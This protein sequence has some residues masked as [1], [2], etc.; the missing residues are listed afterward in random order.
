M[1]KI[2]TLLLALLLV[3]PAM[4]QTSIYLTP[5]SNWV[6]GDAWFAMYT[7]NNSGN[8]WFKMTP[9]EGETNL[10][11]AE[12]PAGYTNIIFC[13]MNPS[14]TALDWSAKWDQTN[15]LTYTE[16]NHFTVKAG[17]WNNA[18]GTWSMYS[19]GE[20]AVTL[21]YSPTM[22]YVGDVVTF[23]AEAQDC[24]NN[25]T[26]VYYV[27][28]T[29]LASNTWTATAEGEHTAKVEAV[30]NSTVKAVGTQII[31]V[32][33]KDALYIRGIAGNW[34]NGIK[35]DRNGYIYTWTGDITNGTEFKF[36][37][38]ATS[39]DVQYSLEGETVVLEQECKL[40]SCSG[41]IIWGGEDDNVTITVDLT[42]KE[43]VTM[44]VTSNTGKKPEGTDPS[45]ETLTYNVTVPAG[46]P[47]CYIAGEMN[48]WGFT[49]MTMVD[50]T[51]YTITFDNVTR[52]MKYKYTASESWE[53]VEMQ[54][55]GVTDVLDRTYSE[56]DV[57]AAWKGIAT[58][59]PILETLTYN[60][61]VPAGTPACYI[62]GEMNSWGFTA[63][64][65]V[66]E[67][68]YTITFD[69]VTRAMKYKYTAS[70]SWE[71]V[72]MQA[73]G[74]TDV[75]DRTYSEND[76]VAAWKGI[77]TEEPT[78]ETLTYYVTVPA[79]TEACYIVGA[80]NEWSA[81][82]VM[83]KVD[84]THFTISIDNT[85]KSSEYKYTCGESWEYEEV[86]ADGGQAANRTW[87]AE[88]VVVAWKATPSTEPETPETLTYNVTV[89]EGT[90]SCF[91]AG[92]MNSWTFTEM[93]RVDATHYTITFDD[94]T[95]STEYK[96]FCGPDFMY[97]E[98]WADLNYR[99]NRTYSENDVVEGWENSWTSVAGVEANDVKVYG[100]NG[101]LSVR[102]SEEV[103]L[104]IYNAQGMLVKAVTVDGSAD[105]NLAAGL[106]IV[107][108]TKVVVR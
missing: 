65:M 74:V 40:F 42:D 79:G 28:D 3:I 32:R 44:V 75:L 18:S 68:H 83:D 107:N 16:N 31:T 50:E 104:Y 2:T 108:G 99:S 76:V 10:Y 66:D 102:A 29:K 98:C 100:A 95:K 4:A 85:T 103:A 14:S 78:P 71:N 12:L 49:A 55:D 37:E 94:V 33:E 106:Y 52:A 13:R 30:V 96:Y 35:M 6:L 26:F 54:A 97:A 51:H 93:T 91:I 62:A 38:D 89:P 88:D 45:T 48:S 9:V 27:D 60:V 47:A 105:I 82:V 39:W 87:S 77:A 8:K 19:P 21:S 84:D 23:S 22:V 101:V 86:T 67:T 59:E 63:M 57:V 7:W 58:E 92:G 17:D 81:F 20:P 11:V 34:S 36:T 61:T 73:D 24:G 46:T 25:P 69:N 41:N 15:D 72:E 43:N 5:N 70:E 64:T 90:Y 56:N 53:N 1:K 80:F